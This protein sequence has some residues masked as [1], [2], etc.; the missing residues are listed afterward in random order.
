MKGGGGKTKKKIY[1]QQKMK[2]K[3]I[4]PGIVPKKKLLSWK[5]QSCK[6]SRFTQKGKKAARFGVQI[7]EVVPIFGYFFA[8]QSS[9]KIFLTALVLY[10]PK[11][12]WRRGGG[13]GGGGEV[14][15]NN[16]VKK[17]KS[18]QPSSEKKKR[19]LL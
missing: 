10:C 9:G 17:K 15:N 4:F 1:P 18:F 8:N 14:A 3:K 7:N 12:F 16:L 6:V 5:I 13:G 19:F 2:K 11:F